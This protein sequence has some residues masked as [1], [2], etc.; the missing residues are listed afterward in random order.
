MTKSLVRSIGSAMFV[1]GCAI[2]VPSFAAAQPAPK[3]ASI[4]GTWNLGLMGGDHV[5]PVALVLEQ[6]GATLKGTYIFMGR[7]FAFAG[8]VTGNTFTLNGTSPLLGRPGQPPQHSGT[9]PAGSATQ[10]PGDVKTA[11]G[12]MTWTAQRVKK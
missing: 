1:A 3:P 6:D 7:E 9:A 2:A 8:N 11:M 10:T 4:A 12:A 5:I